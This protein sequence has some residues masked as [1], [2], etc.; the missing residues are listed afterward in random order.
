MKPKKLFSEKTLF[1]NKT[2]LILLFLSLLILIFLA[3]DFFN[4]YSYAESIYK[5]ASRKNFFSDVIGMS[6]ED[7][8]KLEDEN[9]KKII[10]FKSADKE[11]RMLKGKD[12]RV[13]QAGNFEAISIKDLREK[14]KDLNIGGGIFNIIEARK[15]G[16]Q[17]FDKYVD[18]GAM[19]ADKKYRN[20]IFQVASN[21]NSL[22]FT[23]KAGNEM[24]NLEAYIHDRTQGPFASISAAPGLILRQY[25][26]FY[27]D[28][29]PATL[30]WQSIQNQIELLENTLIHVINGYV[31]FKGKEPKEIGN[32][33]IEDI[34]VGYHKDVEVIFGQIFLNKVPEEHAVVPAEAGQIINQ[35]FVAAV[36][37]AGSNLDYINDPIAQQIAKTILDANYEGTIRVGMVR[38]KANP[39]ES[40][41]VILT[42]VGGGV[43]RNDY[44]WI[45]QSIEKTKD[46]IV[47]AGIKASLVIHDSNRTILYKTKENQ[48]QDGF[49]KRMQKLVR[50]T[51]GKHVRYS[52]EH[53][54]GKKVIKKA[55]TRKNR[56]NIQK[57]AV[58]LNNN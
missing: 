28:T 13:F 53:V 9:L 18:I 58:A 17:S 41:K 7:F 57:L 24:Q 30:W 11:I 46:L 39:E 29:K 48:P 34:K 51:G 25:Y 8:K 44:D 40:V 1:T 12:G 37:F 4:G 42:L 47:K 50:E 20:G 6:E 55:R 33:K 15:P 23:S 27:P 43:F 21:F 45:A 36:D 49:I 56:K 35:V 26:Y 32:I 3:I 22:E 54:N 19:Q 10:S 2:F 16:N 38:K 5:T 14:T 52:E 31:D